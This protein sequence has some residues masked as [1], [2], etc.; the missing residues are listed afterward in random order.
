MTGSMITVRPVPTQEIGP[1]THFE[2]SRNMDQVDA[3]DALGALAQPLRLRVFRALVQ[4]G[5]DG[6]SAG[7]L[8]VRLGIAPSSLSFHLSRLEAAGLVT[9]RRAHRYI[10]Y[11]V[12]AG[13]VRRLFDFLTEECCEGRPELCGFAAGLQREVADA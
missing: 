11:A 9:A 8:A 6:L 4:A 7:D 12:A 1:Q 3:V 13:T 2:Y 10:F 5:A